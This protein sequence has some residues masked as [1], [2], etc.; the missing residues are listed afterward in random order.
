M[1]GQKHT[2]I[3]YFAVSEG[4]W[5]TDPLV[6]LLAAN[7]CIY[8]DVPRFRLEGSGSG[9]GSGVGWL[10]VPS[11]SKFIFKQR[12]GGKLKGVIV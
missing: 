12:S 6:D 2:Y 7:Y 1:T 4:Q 11:R 9:V 3:V 10:A 8:L 5:H